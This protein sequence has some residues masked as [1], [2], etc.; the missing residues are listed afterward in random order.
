MIGEALGVNMSY[1]EPVEEEL[2]PNKKA[3]NFYNLLE[4]T[5]L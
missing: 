3:Q 5:Y 2:P 1:D 4:K